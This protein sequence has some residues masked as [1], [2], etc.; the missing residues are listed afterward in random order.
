MNFLRHW[1]IIT[2]LLGLI[3]VSGLAGGLIGHRVA[4]RHYEVRNDPENWNEHVAKEFERVVKP[5]PEQGARIQASLDR[6]VR[7]LQT[8]RMETIA[9]S[10][11][12]IWRLVAEVDRELTQEQQRSFET[13]KPGP[14]DL[15]LD[16][17]KVKT[18]EGS[19]P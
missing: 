19:Q 13:M 3:L 17:L 2:A 6:A 11:N 14:R 7:E 18:P 10:T 4:R 8:I 9:R 5:S 12:V 16:V 1:R 15:T